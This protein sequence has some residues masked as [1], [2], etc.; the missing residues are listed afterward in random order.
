MKNTESSVSPGKIL[1]DR[2]L[3]ILQWIYPLL[4]IFPLLPLKGANCLLALFLLGVTVLLVI[5]RYPGFL[6]SL[7]ANYFFILP[8]IPYLVEFIFF[9]HNGISRFSLE[10]KTLL[11][12]GPLFFP[13]F[14]SLAKSRYIL[15]YPIRAF[16]IAMTLVTIYSLGGLFMDGTLTSPASYSNGAYLLRFRFET[17]SHIHP[18]YYSLF[19][20]V[21]AMFLLSSLQGRGRIVKL[22]AI[23]SAFILITGVLVVAAKTG[24]IILGVCLL[25]FILRTKQPAFRKVLLLVACFLTVCMVAF[26]VPSLRARFSEMFTKKET[27]VASGTSVNQREII[28]H[29]AVKTFRDHF[30]WGTG[31]RNSQALLDECYHGQPGNPLKTDTFNAHNQYLTFGINYGIFV[32]L[33]FLFVL[34]R[35]GVN[36][37]RDPQGIYF[38]VPVIIV[39]FTECIFERQV[40]VYFFALFMS[41]FY[42]VKRN[43]EVLK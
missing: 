27:S 41:Y 36:I 37:F 15:E 24:S 3:R 22:F 7:K 8:F 39:L 23:V 17:I 16:V 20:T 1:S 14:L 13:Y 21:S 6:A 28:F 38:L 26:L 12:L 30:F 18:T 2:I 32:L 9:P 11:I 31:S 25:I 33:L 5:Y 35:A 19:C 40:G 43:D 10:K 42:T 34:F 29:C 4:F